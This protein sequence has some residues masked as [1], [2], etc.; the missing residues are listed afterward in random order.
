MVLES[1]IGA[2]V[3]KREIFLLLADFNQIK[4]QAKLCNIVRGQSM[5]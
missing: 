4:H 1:Y 3:N 2:Y 5:I